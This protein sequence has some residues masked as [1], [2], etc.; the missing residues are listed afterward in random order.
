[1]TMNRDSVRKL[2]SRVGERYMMVGSRFICIPTPTDTDEDYIIFGDV[3][4]VETALLQAKF[5]MTTDPG[6]GGGTWM[7]TWRLDE[8]NI[9]VT[10][11]ETFY[12]RF[13]AA[14]LLAKHRNLL[15][16]DDRVKLHKRILY[17]LPARG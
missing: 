12:D 3:E 5:S 4:A 7:T 14:T 17:D 2:L 8:Y 9:V 16:K 6:Y 10:D 11:N 15:N 13:A 1:M